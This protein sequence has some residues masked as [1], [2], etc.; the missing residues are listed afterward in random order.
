MFRSIMWVKIL[1]DKGIET[2]NYW[3]FLKYGLL[4]TPL[5]S[6]AALAVLALEFKMNV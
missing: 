4:T 1:R 3:V 2:I 5:L 6:A